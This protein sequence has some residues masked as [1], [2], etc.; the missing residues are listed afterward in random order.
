M[1]DPKLKS[2]KAQPWAGGATAWL[3]IPA[4]QY[5]A[6]GLCA[7]WLVKLGF[8]NT[9]LPVGQ[10]DFHSYY[11]AVKVYDAGGNPYDREELRKASEEENARGLAREIGEDFVHPYIYPPHMLS[12]F[13]LF[14]KLGY[15]YDRALFLAVKL[16]CAVFLLWLW[17]RHCIQ[18][19][20][21]VWF[22]LFALLG[23][24]DAFCKD[25]TS[26]N[27]SLI[28]EIPL[29]LGILA[30]V[31]GW[32][33]LFIPLILLGSQFKTLP[34]GL[35]A[36]LW[37]RHDTRKRRWAILS[38]L[39]VAA[40]IAAVYFAF[41]Q[42]SVRFVQSAGSLAQYEAELT[43]PCSRQFIQEIVIR[44]TD[45]LPWMDAVPR[46][47]VANALYVVYVAVVVWVSARRLLRIPDDR[48]RIYAGIVTYAVLAPRIKEYSWSLM[49]VPVFE[50]A[51]HYW[52]SPRAAGWIVVFAT[53][54]FTLPE[55]N[56]I[57]TFRPYLACL[58]LWGVLISDAGAEG[59]N[60][61]TERP[62]DGMEPF[63][64][65]APRSTLS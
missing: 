56:W 48:L 22:V 26:G 44:Y 30:L 63:L 49:I 20:L 64:A 29:W 34:L 45:I 14:T 42:E 33:M 65:A 12:F 47:P 3:H 55:L 25:I 6:I 24:N 37:L 10:W 54:V 13:R 23:F 50:L 36:L 61:R 52:R 8:L 7:I 18:P 19:G 2:V 51:R 17:S 27:V 31:N 57:Q 35:L 21:T 53:V 5:A 43:N 59:A 62:E 60:S 41:P 32:P 11:Y 4:V 38:V 58:M 9:F 1:G 46:R 39:L 28:E 15:S 16:I 40:N